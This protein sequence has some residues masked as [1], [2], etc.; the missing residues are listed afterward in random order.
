MSNERTSVLGPTIRFKGELSADEDLV[1][2][3]KIDGTINH[4]QRLTIGRDGIVNAN[5]DAQMVV[6]EGALTGNVRADKS[7]TVRETARLIGNIAAPSVAILEGANFSG[8][9]DM[10][11]GK[12]VASVTGTE[13]GAYRHQSGHHTGA[14]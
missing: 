8:S 9:V 5:I 12:A 3:G 1:I 4:K 11:G 7:V 10:S 13:V 2:Q 14:A 6:V